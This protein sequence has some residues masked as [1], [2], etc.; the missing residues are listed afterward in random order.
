MEIIN[1]LLVLAKEDINK[2]RLMYQTNLCY[3]HFI[4]YMDFL[5]DNEFLG[6]KVGN[7]VGKV[8][9]ITEK[10]EKFVEVFKNVLDLM[11]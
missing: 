10:G 7:P 6:E 3:N 11:E 9:Y 8:Y 4:K 1:E 2:T 5:L